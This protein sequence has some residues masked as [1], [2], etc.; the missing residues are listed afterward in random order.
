MIVPNFEL[1]ALQNTITAYGQLEFGW[2]GYS[3]IAPTAK[4]ITDAKLFLECLPEGFKIPV[5]MVA[6]DG[7]I[8]FYWR[9][10]FQY[11]EVGFYGDDVFTFIFNTPSDRIG[12]DDLP[13]TVAIVNANFVKCLKQIS[14]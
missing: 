6:S 9:D 2:D 13:I 14:D 1:I 11:L 5:P 4:A 7:E 12:F 10:T 8:S 3:G